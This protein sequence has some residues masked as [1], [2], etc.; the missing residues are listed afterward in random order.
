MRDAAPGPSGQTPPKFGRVGAPRTGSSGLTRPRVLGIIVV[1]ILV[2]SAFVVLVLQ[3][4]PQPKTC[5]T[6]NLGDIDAGYGPVDMAYDNSSGRIFVLDSGPGGF[7]AW[8][9]T[10]INGTSDSVAGFIHSGGRPGFSIDALAYDPRNGDL[11]T[12]HSCYDGI[13]VLN[14]ATGENVTYINTP[15]TGLCNGP[16]TIAY[17]PVSGYVV[18]LAPPNLTVI[19]PATNTVVRTI[20]L[21]IGSYPLGIN[22]VTGQVYVTTSVDEDYLFN[23]TVLNGSSFSVES[24]IQLN[25][26]PRSMAFDP[27]TGRIY[28]AVELFGFGAGVLYNNGSLLVL[29]GAGT[30]VLASAPIGSEPDEI[31]VDASNRNLYVTNTYS[32]NVSIINGTTNNP[33]GSVPVDPD[34]WS[35]VY[36]ARNGCLYTLF[37]THFSASGSGGDGYLTVLAPPGSSCPAIP[38]GNAPAWAV[39]AVLGLLAIV[40]AAAVALPSRRSRTHAV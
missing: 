26:S 8:G 28:V 20:N 6:C 5:T 23:L 16:E 11:Y 33:S 17:D 36:D 38:T 9:V 10:V 15:T 2:G 39:P 25:G 34:P 19:D 24:S 1:A 12:P 32:S 40:V 29:N 35:I 18:A 21:G 31:A 22:P 14:A 27:M 3:T 4:S 37:Y 30:R 7:T 13:F